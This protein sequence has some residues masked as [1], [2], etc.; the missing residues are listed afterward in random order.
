MGRYVALLRG[1]NVGGN[2]L[3]PMA[4]LRA[5]LEKLGCTDVATLVQSGNVVFTSKLKSAAA[6]IKLLEPA[7]AKHFGFDVPVLVRTRDELA[8]VIANN[9]LPDA[10]ED[11]SRFLIAFLSEPPDPGKLASISP[12]PYL[13]DEFRVVG[14]EIYARFAVGINDSKL[15]KVLLAPSRLGVTPTTRNWKTVTK[16]LVLA[17]QAA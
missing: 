11:P 9:P 13:P 2:K 4:D 12:T 1:V 10:V 17:D 3:V 5:L 6:V 8:A 7:I 14:R 16:L 15:A